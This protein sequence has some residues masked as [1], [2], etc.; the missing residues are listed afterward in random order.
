[1]GQFQP[2]GFHF[3]EFTIGQEMESP[4]RTVTEADVV[5]FAALSGDYNQLHTDAEYAKET[6]YGQRIA[7]GLL[8][9]SI[10]SGLAWRAGFL[11]GT[12]QAFLSLTWR[13]KAPILIGDAIRLKVK[14]AK[15]RP[16]PSMGGGVIILDVSLLNQGDETVQKGEWT[17][18]IKGRDPERR[19]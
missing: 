15:T 7:H 8:G 16:M 6:P 10:A 19:E 4:A 14:V 11:E 17:M 12:V 1:M 2:R 9:L 3:E 13:F 18:L 5:Q